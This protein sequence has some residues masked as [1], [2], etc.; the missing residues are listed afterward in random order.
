[1]VKVRQRKGRKGWQVDILLRLPDGTRLRERVKPPVSTYSGALRWG[2]QREATLLSQGGRKPVAAAREVPT[3]GDFVEQ[4]MAYSKT[5]NKPST[6]HAKEWLLRVHLVPAFG[7]M[8]LDA[9]GPEELERYKAAKLDEGYEKKS[10]NNHLTAL[11][12]LLNLAVEWN[13]L[14]RAPKVRAFKLGRNIVEEDEYLTFE[15]SERFL[16]A[17]RPSGRPFSSWRSGPASDLASCSRSSGR[18]STWSPA[19]SLCAG[20]YG[21][22]RKAHRRAAGP[23]R[24]PSPTRPWR[25]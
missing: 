9:I 4:F 10:I 7:A 23:V 13:K 25:P 20:R 16:R 6:V 17:G 15:E 19:R 21:E 5:N 3:L 1:M 22:T 8:R 11:R 18:T 14:D 2:Q 12:K 24:C